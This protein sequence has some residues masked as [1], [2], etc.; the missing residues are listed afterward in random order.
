MNYLEKIFERMQR[1][2]ATPVVGEVRDGKIVSFT[3]GELLAMVEKARAFIRASGLKAGDRCAL[4]GPN[5]VRWIAVDL[6]LMAQGVV[7][8]PL[9]PRQVAG[10]IAA[11]VS[12]AAPGMIFCSDEAFAA[13]LPAGT[14]RIFFEEIFA[15]PEAA[16]SAP[17]ARKDDEPAT[18]V[19]TSGTSGEQKGAIITVGNITFML[20]CT[21]ARLDILMGKRTEPDRVFQ[22]A[23]FCFGAA[24][25]LLLT[26]LSRNSMLTLSTDLTK[27][28]D[29]LKSAQPNYFVNVPLF[30]ERVKRRVE[31][32]IA[33]KG[34]F[35]A[36]AFH[37]ARR[38]YM[39]EGGFA[40]KIYLAIANAMIFPA[41]RK[42]V[43]P[44]VKALICGSAPLAIET[45][46]F[47]M[48]LGIPVL[49]VYGL[50]ET[51]AICTMDDPGDVAPGCVGRAI[52]GI[53]MKV[54]DDGEIVVRGPN[55]FAGYWQRPE[56]TEKALGGGWFHTGDQGEA[57]ASGNWRITGRLKNLLILNSGHNVAPEPLEEKLAS[58]LPEAQQVML[59]GNQRNF[60][61]ALIT[62]PGANGT[63]RE[64]IQNVLDAMNA[65]LPHYKQI[66]GFQVLSETFSAENGLLTTMGKLKRDAIA[67]RYADEIEKVHAKRSA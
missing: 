65:D 32:S 47:F 4:Y 44:N 48:M 21:N 43:G 35:A 42:S 19:Y 11:V 23:P 24:R 17:L 53:E 15:G 16:S 12:D 22:Y 38:A 18:I 58:L 1:A 49:Q 31:E 63:Q 14:K 6:A 27:L 64:R 39:G 60:L 36:K 37:G 8:V 33:K 41:I 61:G 13:N 29:E 46:K 51:T 10:E 50:T 30:L 45:Q 2:S 62:V 55:V 59:T 20:G 9:D 3:G 34:G 40:D 54:A 66:R 57:D 5:R 7:I 56:A 25:I 67:S 52:P 26:S 28:S